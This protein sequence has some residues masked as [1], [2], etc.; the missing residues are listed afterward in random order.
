MDPLPDW[1]AHIETAHLPD[2]SVHEIRTYPTHKIPGRSNRYCKYCYS[3]H[4]DWWQMN[5]QDYSGDDVILCG[6]CH[7]TSLKENTQIDP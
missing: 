1:P 3:S 4:P 2:G 6:N 5:P 7:Y